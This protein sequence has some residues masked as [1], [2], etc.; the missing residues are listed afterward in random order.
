M[1]SRANIGKVASW[2]AHRVTLITG[3]ARSGKSRHAL[4]LAS[5]ATRRVFIATAEPSDD[6]M[7]E[8]VARHRA[9]RKDDFVT[10]EAPTD[11]ARA[12]ASIPLKTGV[13]VVDC[14]TVWLG[15]LVHH[16][17]ADTAS[18]PELAG[19]LSAVRNPR[20]D[21]VLVTNELGMGLVPKNP[22][23][24]RFRDLA[25]RVNQEVACIADEVILMISGI[26]LTIKEGRK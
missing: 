5:R 24:R 26:P 1:S 10:V 4:S 9:E 7:R 19:F 23:G 3:G 12:L 13:A 8:R 16:R 22:L 20:C 21:L 2:H 6:E 18:F 17:G 15:N 14:L 25:G 11:I